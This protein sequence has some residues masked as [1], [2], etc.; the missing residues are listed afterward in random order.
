LEI[1][2][3]QLVMYEEMARRER[4][5]TGGET[6]GTCAYLEGAVVAT[7]R[8]VELV[9]AVIRAGNGWERREDAL[10][11]PSLVQPSGVEH[12]PWLQSEDLGVLP[13]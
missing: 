1:L 9:E 13:H 3:A 10:P 12:I 5:E 11:F 6:H 2:R 7:Q 4:A 8:A